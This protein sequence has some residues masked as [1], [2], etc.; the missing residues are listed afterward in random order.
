MQITRTPDG[1]VRL[2]SKPTWLTLG[3][4]VTLHDQDLHGPGE[5]DITG[6]QCQQLYLGKGKISIIRLEDLIISYVEGYDTAIAKAEGVSNTH[7]L[8]VRTDALTSIDQLR[9]LIKELDPG[10]VLLTG[11]NHKEFEEAAGL[12]LQT[13]STLKVTNASLPQEGCLLATLA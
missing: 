12:S 7:L 6:I 5:Y 4:S 10:Y 3:V 11:S 9:A 1:S 13:G 2:E 8:V